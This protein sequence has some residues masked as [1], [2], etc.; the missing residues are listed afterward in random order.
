MNF[1]CQKHRINDAQTEIS[2]IRMDSRVSPESFLLEPDNMRPSGINFPCCRFGLNFDLCAFRCVGRGCN[3]RVIGK[4]ENVQ[5]DEVIHT[6]AR[7]D[8]NPFISVLAS[9]LHLPLFSIF[10]LFHFLFFSSSQQ[11]VTP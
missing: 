3:R 6:H 7:S 9:L 4:D 1:E 10:S 8:S 2:F 5:R 11:R